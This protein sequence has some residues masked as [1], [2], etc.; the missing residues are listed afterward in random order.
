MYMCITTHKVHFLTVY[1]YTYIIGNKTKATYLGHEECCGSYE[2]NDKYIQLSNSIL[3]NIIK[4]YN[5]TIIYVHG[6][7]HI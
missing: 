4:S 7:N 2:N 1:I 6:Y 5:Y 3:F